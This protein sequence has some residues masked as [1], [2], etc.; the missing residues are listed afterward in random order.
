MAQFDVIRLRSGEW[1][2]D[3][4]SDLLD[5]INTR[6]VVPLRPP[7]EAPPAHPRLV[8]VFD[9]AGERRLMATHFAASVPVSELGDT[10]ASLGHQQYTIKNALDML[11]SSV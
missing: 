5:G 8:P 11:L 7:H 3:C 4:Q 2:I 6:F 10:I 9:V 1:V